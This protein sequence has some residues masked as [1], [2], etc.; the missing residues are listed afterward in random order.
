MVGSHWQPSYVASIL[1]DT[2]YAGEGYAS[3]WRSV[4]DPKSGRRKLVKTD[5]S[6]WKLFG[7]VSVNGE[8]VQ[9]V[10]PIVDREL[11]AA[12]QAILAGNRT[13]V[14]RTARNSEQFLLRAGRAFCGICGRPLYAHSNPRRDRRAGA[15]PCYVCSKVRHGRDLPRE[16]RPKQPGP[17]ISAPRADA[18]VWSAATQLLNR[19]EEVQA[20][21]G[22]RRGSDPFGPDIQ[23]LGREMTRMEAEMYQAQASLLELR[24]ERPRAMLTATMDHLAEQLDRLESERAELGERQQ[25]WQATVDAAGQFVAWLRRFGGVTDDMPYPQRRKLIE[26]L[27]LRLIVYPAGHKPRVVI[28]GDPEFS[29]EPRRLSALDDL[30][31]AVSSTSAGRCP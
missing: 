1:K 20:R 8:Q 13:S 14:R 19:P 9:V 6:A 26:A 30:P 16:L 22:Q 7:T 27:D 25:R 15:Y 11:F 4:E 29:G 28:V 21:L 12:A 17:K 10:P 3:Q 31:R 5:A 24:H 2:S 18:L 23:A